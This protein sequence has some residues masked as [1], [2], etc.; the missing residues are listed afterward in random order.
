MSGIN[1]EMAQYKYICFLRDRGDVG[2]LPYPDEEKSSQTGNNWI[3]RDHNG[4]QLAYINENGF[5]RM[6]GQ[7]K[8]GY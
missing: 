5:V 8:Y 7:R 2:E 1:Y 6:A 4:V 3:L